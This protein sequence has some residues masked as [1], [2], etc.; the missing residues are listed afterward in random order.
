M[1]Q[2]SRRNHL[3]WMSILG[4]IPFNEIFAGQ[5]VPTVAAASDLQ[6]VL[7]KILLIFK[8]DTGNTVN[9]IFGSS[10]VL[11]TQILQGA[12]FHLFMAADE[13]YVNRIEL[14]GKASLKS[15]EYASGQL[16]LFVSK[17]ASINPDERL[18]DLH[19]AC[20]DGRLKKFSIANPRHAP[21][22]VRAKEVLEKTGL[23][24]VVKNRLVVA[25]NVSQAAQ[26]VS[27]RS[28]QAGLIAHSIAISPLIA[29]EGK[30]SLVSTELYSPLIQKMV[31]IKNAPDVVR[32]LFEYI[33]TPA[34]KMMLSEYGFSTS[35]T[36]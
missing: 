10:G 12:P 24:E 17:S 20:I 35:P 18:K 2:I 7:P 33:Q 30:F 9:V 8:R 14:A 15:V 6:Y 25:E 3:G 23:F 21:Y 1:S 34:V 22:G 16:V 13:F 32:H 29:S 26:Y 4:A 11:C 19:K 36:T 5:S 27:S 31:L 28:A